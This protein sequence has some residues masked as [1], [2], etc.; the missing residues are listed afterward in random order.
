MENQSPAQ[1]RADQIRAFHAESRQ[2]QQAGLL[3][4]SETQ[5]Q[6]IE[7]Y[8][9]TL[10]QQLRDREN[11][12]LTEQA[13][14]LTLGVQIVSFIG[15]CALS[16]SLFFLFYQYW[17]FFSSL[18]QTV[19]L[20]L[21]PLLFFALSV[22]VC[23]RDSSGYYAKLVGMLAF[24]SFVLQVIMLASIYNM[25]PSPNALA[26]YAGYGFL[27]AY[28]LRAKLLLAA[29]ILCS[30]AFVG[31][32][33]GTWMGSY[34]LYMGERPE[35]FFIPSLAF[36]ILPLVIKQKVNRDFAFH[37]QI[38]AAIAFFV[39]L[40]ILANWGN[41][42]YLPWQ[43]DLI[44][45]FYQVLGFVSAGLLV[46]YGLRSRQPSL[47]FAGNVFFALFL[48]TKFFDWWWDWLPKYLFF[49]LITLVAILFMMV[50][51]RLRSWQQ[52]EIKP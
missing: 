24:A 6:Q 29:A 22:L 9:Q 36:F 23:Q 33:I 10:L 52:Q 50:F 42:S 21:A 39:A 15:A 31:A 1:L 44:E 51:N 34:W 47:M 38:W 12:D 45:G 11:V 4:L 28:M 26:L 13:K 46:F 37:Y 18:Q 8:H 7:R 48:F 17:G 3:S 25:A 5:Q 20:L 19:I 49:L 32:K 30:L 43:S 41:T 40:L 16:A 35:Q 2:L 14:H 27:L